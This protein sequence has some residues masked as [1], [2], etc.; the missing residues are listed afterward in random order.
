MLGILSF[1]PIGLGVVE[2][3]LVSFFTIHGIDVSLAV[4]I[5]IIIRLF[6]RWYGVSFGFIALKLSGGL[7]NNQDHYND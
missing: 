3:T 1:L 2:G 7:T 6:T 5:V 4:T